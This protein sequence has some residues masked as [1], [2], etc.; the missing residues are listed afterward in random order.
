MLTEL[1]KD[2]AV[3]GMESG[4]YPVAALLMALESMIAPVPSEVVMPPL[5]MLIHQHPERFGFP[6]AILWSSFGS[7][8]G[9]L[10]SFY[11]GYW[12]GKPAVM[13]VGKWFLLNEHHLDLTTRWFH[14]WGSLTVFVCR[15]I[16]VVRHF[17]SIPAGIA[18]MSLPK[19]CL[20]TIVGATL[21]N[22]FLLWLGHRLERH[23]ETILKYRGPID[24]AVIALLVMAVIAWYY[25]NLRKPK[26]VQPQEVHK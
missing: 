13:K 18:R 14:R 2:W 20:Y 23:W 9:S 21:W 6:G 5:G 3:R 15:F 22:S 11:L 25:L 16:P 26:T 12:G 8:V 24:V 7:L 1:L 4:G 19:F 17:I 10:I